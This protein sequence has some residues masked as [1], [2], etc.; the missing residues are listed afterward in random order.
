MAKGE[1]LLEVM[2]S[3]DLRECVKN[4][5]TWP[6]FEQKYGCTKEDIESKIRKLYYR[7][8]GEADKII[9]DIDG[10]GKKNKASAKSKKSVEAACVEDVFEESRES[11]ISELDQKRDELLAEETRL[12]GIVMTLEKEQKNLAE[13]HRCQI[14]GMQELSKKVEGIKRSLNE[15]LAKF[16]DVVSITRSIQDDMNSVVNKKSQAKAE[17]DEVRRKIAE[18]SRVTIFVYGDGNFEIQ[19][20][21]VELNSNGCDKKFQELILS[22]DTNLGNLRVNEVKA[23]AKAICIEKNAKKSSG[24][25]IEFVFNDKNLEDF[26]NKMSVNY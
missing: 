8:S 20:G 17:L 22:H 4:G 15:C 14:R 10:N 3:R 11:E 5:Y 16:K 24:K 6:D 18:L 7:K 25:N 21:D 1:T 12:S 19:E 26:F 13:K 23:I 2:T 9:R